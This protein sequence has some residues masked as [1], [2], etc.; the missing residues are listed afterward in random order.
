MPMSLSAAESWIG[1][2]STNRNRIFFSVFIF[3]L[4][5]ACCLLPDVYCHL[6]TLSARA[7]TDGGIVRPICFAV[8]QID[9]ELKLHRTLYWEVGWLGAFQDFV[10][11]SS[12]A[13]E[14]LSVN[15]CVRHQATSDRVLRR[16]V[17]RRQPILSR[18]LHDKVSVRIH[19]RLGQG[20]EGLGTLL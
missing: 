20:D 3:F 17:H 10:H 11:I 18:E 2:A 19:E 5:I 4:I 15:R 7:S 8:F 6:I 14:Q 1:V 16:G 13:A 9:D 12:G